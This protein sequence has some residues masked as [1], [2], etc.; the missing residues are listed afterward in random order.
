MYACTCQSANTLQ[1]DIKLPATDAPGTYPV[2]TPSNHPTS[3]LLPESTIFRI[4]TGAPLPRGAD[5]VLMVE[6]TQLSSADEGGE[7]THVQTLAQVPKGENVRAP[8]SDVLAGDRV[9]GKSA[10]LSAKGGEI[11][12]LVFVGRKAVRCLLALYLLEYR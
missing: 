1:Y 4:N 8:G 5:T 10:V 11:G 12:T 3:Q 7:E 6:D 2:L 9:L